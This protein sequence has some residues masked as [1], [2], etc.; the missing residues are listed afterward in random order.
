MSRVGSSCPSIH[1]HYA[2]KRLEGKVLQMIPAEVA[3]S[4]KLTYSVH[5]AGQDHVLDSLQHVT[6]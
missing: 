6:S 2:L 1:W 3:E 5:V 4:K